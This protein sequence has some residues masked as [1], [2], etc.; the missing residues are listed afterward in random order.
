MTSIFPLGLPDAYREQSPD[1]RLALL[2]AGN[3]Q[4]LAVKKVDTSTCRAFPWST[5][6]GARPGSNIPT[7]ADWPWSSYPFVVGREAPPPWLNVDWLL[8]QFAP[9]RGE[10]RRAYVEFLLAG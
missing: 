3:P 7:L 10:A 2:A 9:E 5:A 1:R 4:I 8:P 6:A